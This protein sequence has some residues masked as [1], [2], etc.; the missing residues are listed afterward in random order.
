MRYRSITAALIGAAWILAGCTTINPPVPVPAPMAE[1]M[2]KPPVSAEPLI[3]QPGHW[4]WTGAAMSGYRA[5]YVSAE[6]HSIRWM[7]GFWEQTGAGQ[8][9]APGTLDVALA[10][11]ASAQICGPSPPALAGAGLWRPITHGPCALAA[12]LLRC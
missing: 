11:A 12:P 10:D 3:W 4:D 5:P 9:L 2:P 7:P 1:T 8:S 6:G